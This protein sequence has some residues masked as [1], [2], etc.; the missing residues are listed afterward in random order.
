MIKNKE[1]P[2]NHPIY[3]IDI[4]MGSSILFNKARPQKVEPEP[5][6]SVEHTRYTKR[7]G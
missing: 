5:E 6:D 7:G 1:N 3:S 2:K 4:D